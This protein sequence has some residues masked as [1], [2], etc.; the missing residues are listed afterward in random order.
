MEVEQRRRGRPVGTLPANPLL[1]KTNKKGTAPRWKPAGRLAELKVPEGYKG[2]WCSKDPINL[3]QKVAEGWRFVNKTTAPSAKQVGHDAPDMAYD[4][5]A[6]D[7]VVGFRDMVGM[8]LPIEDINGDGLCAK[9]RQAWLDHQNDR[10][11]NS[12]INLGTEKARGGANEFM[13]N[14]VKPTLTIE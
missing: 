14:R 12:R 5:A 4:G 3:Q 6:L 8:M 1:P 13:A 9:E 11:I 10:A 2:R 7:S